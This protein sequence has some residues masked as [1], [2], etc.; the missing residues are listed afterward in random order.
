MYKVLIADDKEYEREHLRQYIED[1]YANDLEIVFEAADG[2]EVMRQ[3]PETKP[4]I[5]LLDIIMPKLDGLELSEQVRR[6]YPQITIVLISAHAEFSY[7]KQALRL[8]VTDYLLKPYLDEE[9][10]ETLDKVLNEVDRKRGEGGISSGDANRRSY[11]EN[12]REKDGLLR[13][14]YDEKSGSA[15]D[16]LQAEFGSRDG[17]CK[18]I[19]FYSPNIAAYSYE[20][21]EIVKNMFHRNELAVSSFMDFSRIVIIAAGRT[22]ADFNEIEHCVKRARTYISDGQRDVVFCGVS[23]FVDQQGALAEA[24]REASD[25]IGCY[26]ADKVKKEFQE[27]ADLGRTYYETE[28]KISL[29]IVNR[30]KE[31]VLELIEELSFQSSQRAGEKHKEAP[32][33]RMMQTIYFLVHNINILLESQDDEEEISALAEEFWNLKKEKGDISGFWSGLA[34]TLISQIG[35]RSVYH[36]VQLVRSAKKYIEEH[37]MEKISLQAIAA[38]LNISFGYL[39]K[40]FKQTEGIALTDYLL[41]FRLEKAMEMMRTQ[42]ITV[43]EIGYQVGF[44]D[45]NYF[46]KCFKKQT[47]MSPVEYRKMIIL[48]NL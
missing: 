7:A 6:L 5:L 3:I 39:S 35:E 18:C 24:Y 17:Y 38:G 11:M 15:G 2:A 40:C 25:F 26:A 22:A 19:V 12:M 1:C 34:D 28:K 44:T 4:D 27:D 16:R 42:N 8:G 30:K 46:S 13:A 20:E 10:K 41:A 23:G 33:L 29:N 21:F 45:P 37:Y 36:N 31:K 43:S 14:L 47:G 9:L 48:E 32:D